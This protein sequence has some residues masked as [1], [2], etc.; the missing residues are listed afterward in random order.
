MF[1]NRRGIVS[2]VFGFSPLVFVLGG[3]L[4]FIILNGLFPA[5]ATIIILTGV[6]SLFSLFVVFASYGLPG[7]LL[8]LLLLAIIS[9]IKITT[10][11]GM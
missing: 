8:Y 10:M 4:L 11:V 1:K 2:F 3:T 7:L 9:I 5:N 6:F